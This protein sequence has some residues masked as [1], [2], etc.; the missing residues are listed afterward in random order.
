MFFCKK[1]ETGKSR[2]LDIVWGTCPRKKF[3]LAFRN[4]ANRTLSCASTT[5]DTSIRVDYV[6][7]FAFA[8]SRYRA[9]GLA[10]TAFDAFVRN[11]VWHTFCLLCLI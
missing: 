1:K 4:S 7:V 11:F 10:S 2:S 9:S 5:I 8:D 3:V 6:S